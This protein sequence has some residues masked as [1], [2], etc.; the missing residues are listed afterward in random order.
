MKYVE[1]K[2]SSL[3]DST[4]AKNIRLCTDFIA[5]KFDLNILKNESMAKLE[6]DII[7]LLKNIYPGIALV[8]R[9]LDF[10]ILNLAIQN[11]LQQARLAITNS[12]QTGKK[13]KVSEED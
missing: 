12:K 5:K 4:T 8:Q 10:D 1:V 9:D 7:A 3:I 2:G 11:I 6:D 13:R